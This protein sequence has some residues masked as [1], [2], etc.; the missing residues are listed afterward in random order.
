MWLACPTCHFWTD[1]CKVTLIRHGRWRAPLCTHCQGR[2]AAS[3]WKCVC[4]KKWANCDRHAKGG[5][6]CGTKGQSVPRPAKRHMKAGFEIDEEGYPI[7]LPLR[8]KVHHKCRACKEY[9]PHE[10]VPPSTGADQLAPDIAEG[11]SLQGASTQPSG[12]QG[13]SSSSGQLKRFRD[14][15]TSEDP[16]FHERPHARPR[17]GGHSAQPPRA[18]KRPHDNPP[19]GNLASHSRR[20]LSGKASAIQAI[21]RLREAR[22]K[23]L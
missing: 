2:R 8:K 18:P 16:E 21:D 20:R 11:A 5:L 3:K 17:P 12:E 19:P 23:P 13:A 6:A 22:D 15:P 14:T 10:D 9:P 4:N 7:D 1:M